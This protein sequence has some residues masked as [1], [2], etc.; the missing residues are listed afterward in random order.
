MATSAAAVF[1]SLP[2]RAAILTDQEGAVMLRAGGREDAADEAELQRMAATFAVTAE[3]ASKLGMG[4]SQHATAFYD[5][6]IVVHVSCSPLV[7]TMLTDSD[8][9]VGLLLDAVPRLS[10][11]VEPLR[12]AAS[13]T[14]VAALAGGG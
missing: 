4:K 5:K 9:N 6:A 7:L 2:L 14:Q 10:A 12:L 8:A 11:A 3:H 1:Q 13:Q